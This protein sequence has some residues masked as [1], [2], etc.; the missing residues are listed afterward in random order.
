[1]AEPTPMMKQYFSIKDQHPDSLL[2]FRLG[3]F[4]ELFYDDAVTA[5]KVLEITLTSRDKNSDNPTPMCGVP[6]HSARNYIAKLIDHGFKVAIC[7]QMENP[8]ETKGMVKRE[9]VRVITPG[10]LIDDFG[11]EDGASNYILALREV[12]QTY[13]VAYGDISTGEIHAFS[14]LNQDDLKSEIE[15]IGASEL[16]VDSSSE[17]L[18]SKIYSDPPLYT[19]FEAVDKKDYDFEDDVVEHEAIQL[20]LNY[21][22]AQNMRDLEHL[23][24]VT[25]H[26]LN[27]HMKLNYAAVSN[28]ELLENIQTKKQKGSLF[29]YLNKTETP[30]GKRRLKNMIERPLVSKKEIENRQQIVTVLIDHFSEREQLSKILNHVYDIERLVG[31]LSFN[32]IDVKD[33]VQL[34]DSLEGLPELKALLEYLSLTDNQLFRNFDSL[35]DVYEHLTVFTDQPPKTIREGNIFKDG[36]SD[37][38]DELRDISNNARTWLNNYLEDEKERTGLKNLK[39]GFNKVFGYYLE[40]SKGQAVNFDADKFSYNRKQT[41]TNAERFITPELKDMESKILTAEDDSIMLEYKMFTEVRNHMMAY[42]DRLQHTASHLS[43]L[44]TLISFAHVSN[45]HHLIAPEFSSDRTL[46]L[47]EARHPIVERMLN[48]STYVPNDLNMTDDDF[49]YLITGPNMSGKSTYM[50]QVALI[51]IMAQ[52]GMRVPADKA[53]LPIFDAIYTRIGAS[54]DLSSGKSTFMI[55]MMEA[56]TAL[57]NAT[58]DSLLIFDEIGRGTSTYDGMALAQAMLSYIHDDI[59]AKTLFSTHYHELTALEN[60]LSGLQNVHVKATEYD[61]K[62]VFLHKVKPGAVEKSYGIHVARLAELPNKVTELAESYLSGFESNGKQ[63]PDNTI[64]Q[65][66]LPLDDSEEQERNINSDLIEKLESID[67][68]EMTPLEALN[69]LAEMKKSLK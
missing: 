25:K 1:M 30:M 49:I 38:L 47:V 61:G 34:R 48:E 69:T 42:I 45:E 22:R 64:F 23:K 54:D 2:L 56:N 35:E 15:T 58:K 6:Y 32:N 20:L 18:L 26:Q 59:G 46:E 60:D 57:Q 27:A 63:V 3:D 51:I 14:T 21:I 10:T 31:R 50:R 55:E 28:L 7:E 29:W 19:V 37:E 65:L 52:I 11:M 24:P 53:V 9:V 8:R 4:Y 67:L 17:Y 44:D 66:E 12:N 68:N 36:V 16:V 33:F 13:E 62:L 40:I 5:A 41:L 43:M 39:I